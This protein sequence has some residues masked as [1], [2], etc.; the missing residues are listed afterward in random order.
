MTKKVLM[1]S[2]LIVLISSF[3]LINRFQVKNF[4][5]FNNVN[6]KQIEEVKTSLSEV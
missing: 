6:S 4:T 1:F 2:S 5:V 3:L